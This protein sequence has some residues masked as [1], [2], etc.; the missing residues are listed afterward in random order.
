MATLGIVG[1]KPDLK[2]RY[3]SIYFSFFFSFITWMTVDSG[4]RYRK[5]IFWYRCHMANY[6][7]VETAD[8][9]FDNF[10]LDVC[11]GW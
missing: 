3:L 11:P 10:K 2:S 5:M 6:P 1:I 4:S 8:L 7:S 9:Q